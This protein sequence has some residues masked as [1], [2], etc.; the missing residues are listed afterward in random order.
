MKSN[1]PLTRRDFIKLAG[2]GL[3]ALAF[4]SPHF[5]GIQTLPKFPAGDYLGRVAVTPNFYSTELR[6]QPNENAPAIRN[7]NQDEVVVWEREVVGTTAHGGFSTRWVQT[8]DGFIYASHLQPVH[9]LP[10]TPLTSVPGGKPGFWVEVTVPYVDLILPPGASP[11]SPGVKVYSSDKPASPFVLWPGC[12]DR[13]D[14][15]RPERVG[16]L[17]FQR[18]TWP[19]IR[20]WRCLL[21]RWG[22]FPCPDERRCHTHQPECGPDHK[23]NRD[24]RNSRAT[25]PFLL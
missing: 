24:R 25:N 23:E 21:C 18:V 20:L 15:C 11:I 13:S 8:P 17:S 2:L 16:A 7:V 12:M 9:N 6:S 19:W 1:T 3:G 10:N 4:E 14:R 22:R 5:K